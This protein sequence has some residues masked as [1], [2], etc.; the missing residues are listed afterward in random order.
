MQNILRRTW[1]EIDLDR[2]CHNYTVIKSATSADSTIMAVIKADAYGHGA[3]TVAKTYSE[4]GVG[5]FAVSNLEEALQ[6]RA[7][8]IQQPI[9]ILSYTPP[10]QA[11]TLAQNNITQTI[12]DLPHAL[13]F[14]K[15]AQDANVNVRVHLKVDTGMTRVG[16]VHQTAED[17][18]IALEELTTAARLENLIP[19]GIFTH[20]ATADDMDDTMARAQF[21]RFTQT[22]E[23]LADRGI[24]FTF[25]HCCNS[26][27]IERFPEM[28]LDLVRPGII[29]Y[30]LAPDA[31]WMQDLLP[32]KQVMQLKTSVSMV[33]SIKAGTSLSYGATYTAQKDMQIATVSIGYADGYPRVMAGK[34]YML[35]NGQKAP[36]VGRVC[37]DQCML[38]VT[39]LSVK[40]GD[41]VTVFG[42]G[43]S[44]DIYAAWMNTINYEAVCCVGKRVPRIYIKNG[45]Y[46]DCE[47]SIFHPS[48]DEI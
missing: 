15:A 12:V 18:A 22:V 23:D 34:A 46:F 14:Q 17:R 16:F 2:L 25:K 3:V 47:N 43:L 13:A 20:F 45:T 21:E 11:A 27:A 8:D 29:L 48:E 35:V 36:V 38:D 4:L 28:H 37:M 6:L 7:A 32:L 24:S 33:K 42:D 30:G 1:A 19:E 39:D 41:E 5:F 26:A 44:T 31:S 9:L 10:T 40:P